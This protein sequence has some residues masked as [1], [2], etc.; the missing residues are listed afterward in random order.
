MSIN[1]W[2]VLSQT[3]FIRKQLL[4]E[5]DYHWQWRVS[6][7]KYKIGTFLILLSEI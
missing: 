6:S 4:A 7:G 2:G 1:F 3:E 5:N